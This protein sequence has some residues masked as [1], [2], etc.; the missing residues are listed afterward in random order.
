M[1]KHQFLLMEEINGGKRM[2]EKAERDRK[3][4]RNREKKRER[5]R[6]RVGRD[7]DETTKFN[8]QF[9]LSSSAA[10]VVYLHNLKN[11]LKSKRSPDSHF[12][13]L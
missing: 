5:E 8:S 11:T 9:S 4:Q 2:G 1:L 3:R 10:T 6:E 7:R 12:S 13:F